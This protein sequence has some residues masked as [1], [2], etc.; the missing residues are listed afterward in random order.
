MANETE[1]GYTAKAR[2]EVPTKQPV[3]YVCEDCGE[4]D[5]EMKWFCSWNVE[6]QAWVPCDDAGGEYYCNSCGEC[7]NIEEREYGS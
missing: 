2:P 3:Y 1:F 5:V 7:N 6:K 4:D